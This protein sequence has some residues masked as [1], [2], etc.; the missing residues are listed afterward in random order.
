MPELTSRPRAPRQVRGD[1]DARERL[2]AAGERLFGQRPFDSVSIDDISDEAGVAHGLLFH[3]FQSKRGFLLAVTRRAAS[4]VEAMHLSLPPQET[5]EA[6]F[7]AFLKAHMDSVLSRRA[8]FV[9]QSRGS[10]GVDAAV[11]VIWEEARG[12]AIHLF[13][14]YL[15]IRNAPPKLY[16][17]LRAWLGFFDELL[18]SWVERSD[19]SHAEVIDTSI[20]NLR[21]A[22]SNYSLL[23]PGCRLEMIRPL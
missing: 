5:S 8:A 12:R 19:L 7:R 22:L 6:A 16:V 23:D 9:A 4:R 17:L 3:Y 10:V 1:R 18:L 20:A 2:L 11:R 21:T 15:G 13:Y 14:G